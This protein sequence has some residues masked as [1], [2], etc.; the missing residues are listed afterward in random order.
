VEDRVDAARCARTVDGIFV[1][2]AAKLPALNDPLG[3]RVGQLRLG[4]VKHGLQG[5]LQGHRTFVVVSAK[6]G[7]VDLDRAVYRADRP[8]PPLTVLGGAAHGIRFA[9]VISGPYYST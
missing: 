7:V 2:V 5:K 8:R 9:A 1:A 4:V 6:D 3:D